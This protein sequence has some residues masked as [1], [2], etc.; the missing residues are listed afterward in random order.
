MTD[1]ITPK[2]AS[3]ASIAGRTPGGRRIAFS[4]AAGTGGP[5]SS[6][7]SSAITFGSGRTNHTSTNGTTLMPAATSH[8]TVSVA[9]STSRPENSGPNTAGPRIAPNTLPNST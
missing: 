3:A 9:A 7:S 4:G 2:L 5:E 8:G 6:A 1:T